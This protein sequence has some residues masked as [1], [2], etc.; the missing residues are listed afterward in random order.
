[1]PS[2]R[3]RQNLSPTTRHDGRP[4][5]VT[6]A[7]TESLTVGIVGAGRV[8]SSL[9]DLFIDS[10]IDAVAVDLGDDW[11]AL[12]GRAI[13]VEAVTEDLATKRD[14]IHD[15]QR[16]ISPTAVLSTTSSL[17]AAA[18]SDQMPEPERVLL[19]HPFTPVHRRRLVE[20]AATPGAMNVGSTDARNAAQ[21]LAEATDRDVLVVADSPGLVV[22]RILKRWTHA[23]LAALDDGWSADAINAAFVA[24]GFRMGPVTVVRL[25]DPS[26]SL[27]VSRN[28][29][30]GLGP[31]FAPPPALVAA[32]TNPDDLGRAGRTGNA[33]AVVAAALGEIGDEID[34]VLADG[35]VSG[36]T[37]DIRRAL[38]SGAGWPDEVLDA[39]HTW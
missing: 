9:R 21:W 16:T 20:I 13:I 17:T 10:G 25:V 24:A 2:R 14:V 4:T 7:L 32:A 5:I 22:N 19:W 11:D 33:A 6:I 8:G 34:R 37:F 23:G 26:V 18:L 12:T 36:G 39:V 31:R 15:V 29:A 30:L 28:L 3:R 27:A 1:M 38:R 35:L